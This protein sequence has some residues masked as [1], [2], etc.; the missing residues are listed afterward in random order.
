MSTS[1]KYKY[2]YKVQ[3][4]VQVQANYQHILGVRFKKIKKYKDREN[5]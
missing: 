1:T 3:V 5:G 2:K 4:Q